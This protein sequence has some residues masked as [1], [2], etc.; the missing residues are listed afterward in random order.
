MPLTNAE[1]QNRFRL[2]KGLED[3]K[4]KALSACQDLL[5]KSDAKTLLTPQEI[6]LRLDLASEMPPGWTRGDLEH[7]FNKIDR[8]AHRIKDSIKCSAVETVAPKRQITPHV[9]S[10]ADHL[11]SALRISGLDDADLAEAV[12][13]AAQ[14]VGRSLV[15]GGHLEERTSAMA[16]C[17]DSIF[18]SEESKFPVV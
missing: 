7:A 13:A 15:R 4:Q 10:L 14:E 8:E 1:K 12:A 11:I 6:A 9:S 3:W 18:C 2:K 17:I 5:E 16:L